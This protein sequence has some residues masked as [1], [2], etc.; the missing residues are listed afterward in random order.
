MKKI[1][2]ICL[3]CLSSMTSWAFPNVFIDGENVCRTDHP[4]SIQAKGRNAW[5]HKCTVYGEDFLKYVTDENREY[6]Y[7]NATT[8]KIT[9]AYIVVCKKNDEGAMIHFT[10]PISAEEECHDEPVYI[11]GFCPA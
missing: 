4:D 2:T 5:A 10:A 8:G 9:K 11:C 3:V 6:S 1:L 7:Q